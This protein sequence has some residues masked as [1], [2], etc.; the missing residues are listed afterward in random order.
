VLLVSGYT[1]A[2][3]SADAEFVV[4]RKPFQLPE[5]SR[6][7]ASAIARAQPAPNNLVHL[8]DARR[9]QKPGDPRA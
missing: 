3:A 1:Q 5:L 6:A 8:R 7:V 2:A 9:G 4:L